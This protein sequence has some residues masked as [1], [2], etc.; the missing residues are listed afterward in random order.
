MMRVAPRLFDVSNESPKTLELYGVQPGDKR[1]L[2]YQCLMARRLDQIDPA[3]VAEHEI[4]H[5]HRRQR[6]QSR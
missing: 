1:S 3:V 6:E 2:G 4:E 5:D